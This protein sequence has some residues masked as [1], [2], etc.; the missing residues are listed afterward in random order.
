MNGYTLIQYDDGH[1]ARI[2]ADGPTRAG[3]I[4]ELTNR[5]PDTGRI[6]GLVIGPA[7]DDRALRL[8]A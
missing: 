7:S 1:L 6:V 5:A 4:R 8:I 3:L 2:D